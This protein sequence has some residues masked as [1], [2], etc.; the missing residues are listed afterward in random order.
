MDLLSWFV[1]VPLITMVGIGFTKSMNQTR[2]VSAIGMSIQL[3]LAAYLVFSYLSIRATGNTD[4]M[5]F[6]Y[7]AT[8]FQTVKI[9]YTVGVD[10][11]SVAMIALTALV[12]FAGFIDSW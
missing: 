2:W 3:L 7:D 12:V 9:H 4:A 8:W 10:G 1:I 6:V 11:I 5:L